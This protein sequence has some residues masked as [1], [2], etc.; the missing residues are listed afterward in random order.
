MMSFL[1]SETRLDVTRLVLPPAS[2]LMIIFAWAS[3][4]LTHSPLISSSAAFL[5]L[6]SVVDQACRTEAG[7]RYKTR[8]FLRFELVIFNVLSFGCVRRRALAG[9][10]A[11]PTESPFVRIWLAGRRAT[12]DIGEDVRDSRARFRDFVLPWRR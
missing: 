12:V 2:E 3:I 7:A 8:N 9:A 6:G 1:V 4:H 11:S 5:S 10:F